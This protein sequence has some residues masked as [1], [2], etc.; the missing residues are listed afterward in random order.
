LN[1]NAKRIQRIMRKTQ[2]R[3]AAKAQSQP[4]PV[5]AL[6]HSKNYD[7]VQ[8]K[9]KKTLD[10]VNKK[11]LEINLLFM[12]TTRILNDHYLDRNQL[13]VIFF[14]HMKIPDHKFCDL[15]LF[16]ILVEVQLLHQ[17]I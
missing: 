9:V 16:L 1:E 6:W 14:E 10:E 13:K 2:Q 5:K 8:S 12:L 4:K 11:Y 15:N 3:Q 17:L 7:H